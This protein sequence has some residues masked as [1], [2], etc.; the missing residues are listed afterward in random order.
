MKN[1]IYLLLLSAIFLPGCAE[2]RTV[3]EDSNSSQRY[4]IKVGDNIL[5]I[6]N[7]DDTH[8]FE[9]TSI[10]RTTITGDAITINFDDITLLK[11]KE[12][13]TD[14]T[15]KT[16]GSGIGLGLGIAMIVLLSVGI[17]AAP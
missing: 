16:V 7:T 14:E 9:V 15:L 2:Y 8:E 13:D 17:A 11:K 10:S 6:T 12:I 5:V 1:V 4:D 3:S